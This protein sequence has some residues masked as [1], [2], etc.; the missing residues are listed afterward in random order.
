MGCPAEQ[1]TFYASLLSVSFICKSRWTIVLIVANA[2]H[3]QHSNAHPSDP[4]GAPQTA[5]RRNLTHAV[6]GEMFDEGGRVPTD[7]PETAAARQGQSNIQRRHRTERRHGED[8]SQTPTIDDLTR[9][10]NPNAP[11]RRGRP[12]L[13]ESEPHQD[14]SAHINLNG[15]RRRRCSA[16]SPDTGRPR[17]RPRLSSPE[18]APRNPSRSHP[19]Q[20]LRKRWSTAFD[21]KRS[22]LI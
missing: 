8:P 3:M 7:T 14:D 16:G 4:D 17:G 21:A 6:L 22:G 18:P 20:R 1:Q 12:P 19:A 13:P 15:N 11:P 9:E 5:P 10:P 2:H